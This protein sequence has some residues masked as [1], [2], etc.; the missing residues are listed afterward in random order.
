[1]KD[2]GELEFSIVY[3]RLSETDE[4]SLHCLN[5]FTDGIPAMSIV[6]KLE[7]VDIAENQ[8]RDIVVTFG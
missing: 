3:I 4:V 7:S 6:A 5:I 1:M 8:S 2:V